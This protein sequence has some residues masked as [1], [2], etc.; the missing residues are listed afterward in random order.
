MQPVIN[1]G[2]VGHVDHGKTTLVRALSGVWT[3]RHSEEI[4]RGISIRLGYADIVL[5]KCPNCPEPESYTSKEICEIC[6]TK[7]EV[8]RAISFVDSPGHETLMAT[9]LS[10]AALMDGALLVIAANE[11]CPQ[12]Q[13]KEHLMALNIIGIKNIVI[14][15]NKIDLVTRDKVIENYNQI[16][17]FVKD[18]VAENA[19]IIPVSAQQNT[20]IDLVIEAIEKY[21]PTPKRDLDKPPMM[22]VARSFDINKPGTTPDKLLGGVIGGSLSCG[23]LHPG[24][25]IELRPGRKVESGGTVKWV[26]IRTV[27]TKILAGNEDIEEA[28]P[29]GLIGVGTKLDPSLT[30]SDA[31]VGQVAGIPGSIPPTIEGFIMET[32]LLP[33]VVGVSDEYKVEPIRSNEPL[34]LNMGTA[35]TIGIVTSARA[36]DAEVKLK[37][38]VCADRGASI[39]ISRRVGARWRLI[40]SG[41]LKEFK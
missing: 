11:P 9:M 31:L 10:G 25:E 41:T 19:P 29:G 33:R 13:T 16:K 4:K 28:T 21:I 15:Q 34:M 26:S 7:S 32:K 30:K 38:P 3:D 14:I 37:R 8:L 35:T 20:N 12:P 5:R 17:A 40:G 23:R 6:G 22:F 36:S 18:T 27:V 1:I 39:A 24:D 2:I